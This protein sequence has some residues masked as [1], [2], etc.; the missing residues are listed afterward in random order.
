VGNAW[1]M[2]K[3]VMVEKVEGWEMEAGNSEMGWR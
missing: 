2:K 1:E 3:M